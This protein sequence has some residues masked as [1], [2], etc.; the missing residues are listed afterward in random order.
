MADLKDSGGGVISITLPFTSPVWPLQKPGGSCRMAV[1]WETQSSTSPSC[2]RYALPDV[3]ISL[4]A[5]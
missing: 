4:T 2:S 3:I 5:D 1:D